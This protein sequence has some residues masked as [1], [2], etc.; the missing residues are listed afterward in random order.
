M[1]AQRAVPTSLPTIPEPH[2]ARMSDDPLIAIIAEEIG[3]MA[4]VV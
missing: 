2:F 1:S 4:V 3:E